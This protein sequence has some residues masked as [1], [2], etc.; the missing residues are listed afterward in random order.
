[1]KK[2]IVLFAF[3]LISLSVTQAIEGNPNMF[4]NRT[5]LVRIATGTPEDRQLLNPPT[6]FRTSAQGVVVSTVAEAMALVP[7]GQRPAQA[8]W[9]QYVVQWQVDAH[10]VPDV[11]GVIP[12]AM[13]D[14]AVPLV[15][16]VDFW[17]TEQDRLDGDPPLVRNTFTFVFNQRPRDFA[18]DMRRIV[19]DWM[20]QATFLNWTG[21]RRDPAQ[22]A[23]A[24]TDPTDDPRGLLDNQGIQ[25]LDGVPR[26]LAAVWRP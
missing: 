24:S 25:N 19:D 6:V 7:A 23:R 3:L 8:N 4:I 2:L 13:E 10:V 26:S 22:A 5:R 20:I 15:V 21:D 11:I 9:W 12:Y 14:R 1:M 16:D 18:D 17:Q